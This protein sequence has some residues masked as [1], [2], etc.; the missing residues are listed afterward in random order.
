[1][2]LKQ[3]NK[4][5]P[6]LNEEVIINVTHSSCDS[7]PIREDQEDILIKA[8]N[9]STFKTQPCEKTNRHNHKRCAFYHS[10]SDKRRVGSDYTPRMCKMITDNNDE[11]PNKDECKSAH[12]LVEINYHPEIYKR[13]YCQKFMGISKKCEYGNFAINFI[14]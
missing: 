10:S 11:C 13:K 14:R 2:T 7:Q 9:L 6:F 5:N 4:R 12:N 1:M 8:L 3:P